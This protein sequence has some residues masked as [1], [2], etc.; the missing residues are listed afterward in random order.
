[1]RQY[2]K[3]PLH[4]EICTWPHPLHRLLHLWLGGLLFP[5]GL[6]GQ[7]PFGCCMKVF[8]E[9][10]LALSILPS[11]SYAPTSLRTSSPTSGGPLAPSGS[12]NLG[13][14]PWGECFVSIVGRSLNFSWSLRWSLGSWILVPCLVSLRRS[15]LRAPVGGRSGV[16]VVLYLLQWISIYFKRMKYKFPG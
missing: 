13:W 11:T 15:L 4:A 5:I 16:L 7:A 2:Q 10:H 8:I 6:N 1:M 12:L 14:V 9:F 3:Q